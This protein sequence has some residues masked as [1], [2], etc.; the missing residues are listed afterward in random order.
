MMVDHQQVLSDHWPLM[1]EMVYHP[2]DAYK[3]LLGRL[4]LRLNH[5]FLEHEVFDVYMR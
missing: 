1:F 4:P 3:G 5:T 2:V